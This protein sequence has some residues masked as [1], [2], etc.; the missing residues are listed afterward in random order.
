M[1]LACSR[2]FARPMLVAEFNWWFDPKAARIVLCE[3]V[4][5]QVIVPLDV[6]NTVRFG[7]EMY[8]RVSGAGTPVDESG[9]PRSLERLGARGSR[10]R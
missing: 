9:K 5:E 10:A 3:P 6:T 2:R 8:E 1:G 4:R 7:W